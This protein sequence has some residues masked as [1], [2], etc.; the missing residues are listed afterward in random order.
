MSLTATAKSR[1]SATDLLRRGRQLIEESIVAGVTAMRAFVEVDNV[2]GFKCLD[3][4]LA[5][6]SEYDDRCDIQLVAFA[7]LPL[8]SGPDGGAE[9]RR[10]ISEA[11]ERPGVD[12]LGSTPYVESSETAQ[13]MNVRWIASLALRTRKPLDLHLDYHLDAM[14]PPL[15]WSVIDILTSLHWNTRCGGGNNIVLGHCSRLTL[16]SP[17]EWKRLKGGVADLPISF[18]GLP[19]SDL[20]MMGSVQDRRGSLHVPKL[21]NKHGLDVAVAVNNVCNAFTPQGSC[22]PLGVASLGVGVYSAGTCADAELLYVRLL[23]PLD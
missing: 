14:T 21:I 10:L 22:D 2:V 11:A 23:S 19:T 17:D 1:F 9:I 15:V 3:A 18:V 7:Q 16:F 4:G 8:F 13:K 20:F 6:R 5:L 12:V